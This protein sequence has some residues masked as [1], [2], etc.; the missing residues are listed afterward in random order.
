MAKVGDAEK[1]TA[2]L[3][4]FFQRSRWSANLTFDPVKTLNYLRRA[5]HT[6]YAPYVLAFDK[7]QVVGL[8]SYHLYDVFTDP[9][10]VMDE[11]YVDPKYRFT[12]LGRRV[13]STAIELARAEGCKAM[14]F[15]IA[16]GMKQQNGLA[17]MIGRHFGG[18]YVGMIFMVRL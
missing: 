10:A 18:E 17:N 4:G 3:E 6:N 12:D 5:I 8:C 1:V 2:F 16:S 11:T 15:P 14:N 13:V 7:D 9:I